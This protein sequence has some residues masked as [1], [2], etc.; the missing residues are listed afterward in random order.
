VGATRR[1]AEGRRFM[2][3]EHPLAALGPRDVVARAIARHAAA[4]GAD[5]TLDLTHLDAEV[6]R[7][8][9]PTVAAICAEHGLDIARDLIPVT[10]AAHYAIGGALADMSG[11]TTLP[12]LFAVG[13]CAATGA[14]GANRLASNG[15][16]EAAVLAAGAAEALA[17]DLGDWPLGPL[18][19]PSAPVLGQ[20]ATPGARAAIQSAM[21]DG[22]GVER[23]EDG[24]ADAGARLAEIRPGAAPETG[25]LLLVARL[26]A[27]A[28][29]LRAESRGAHFRSDHPLPDALHARRVAWV[30]SEPHLL[31]P[32]AARRPRALAMEAA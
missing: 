30:G 14:H 23:D 26:T 29:D 22:V 9:F 20:E 2:P 6:V 24:L 4:L 32:P 10:P 25:N 28:A 17:G 27:A 19:T 16:L 7:R 5:V 15:L 3:D 21:W 12:G 13:E 1:A 18:G 31:S 8:R 11:R